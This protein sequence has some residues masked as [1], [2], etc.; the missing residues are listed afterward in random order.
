MKKRVYRRFNSRSFVFYTAPSRSVGIKDLQRV[1]F[2]FLG[3]LIVLLWI[4]K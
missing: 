4:M 1:S 2:L 3:F